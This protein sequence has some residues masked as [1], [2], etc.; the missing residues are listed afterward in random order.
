M[1][2]G[3]QAEAE[4]RVEGQHYLGEA[5]ITRVVLESARSRAIVLLSDIS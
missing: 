3:K 5:D 2:H 4:D 1:Y